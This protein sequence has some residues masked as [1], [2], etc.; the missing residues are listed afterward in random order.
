VQ[1]IDSTVKLVT[2]SYPVV[3]AMIILMVALA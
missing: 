2:I 1:I 3:L